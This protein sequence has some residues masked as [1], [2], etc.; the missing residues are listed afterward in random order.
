[1]IPIQNWGGGA[2]SWHSELWGVRVVKKIVQNWW[3]VVLGILNWGGGGG[4]N[5][6]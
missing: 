6:L 2:E 1:M 5:F 4:R 3:R